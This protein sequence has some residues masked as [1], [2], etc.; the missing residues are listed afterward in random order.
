MADELIAING[1]ILGAAAGLGGLTATLFFLTAQLRT[2]GLSQHGIGDLYTVRLIVPLLAVTSAI[3][4]SSTSGMVLAPSATQLSKLLTTASALQMLPFVI[5]VV[6]LA[7]LTIVYFEPMAVARR[8]SGRLRYSDVRE[9]QLLAMQLRW[10]SAPAT[11]DRFEFTCKIR[12]NRMNFGLRDPLMSI[13]ELI[14]SSR[15]KQFG[16]LVGTLFERLSH[17][18]GLRWNVQAPDPQDWLTEDLSFRRPREAGTRGSIV[19]T[20][21][22]RFSLFM[23][24]VHYARRIA[25]NNTITNVPPDVRRQQ[26]QF[27]LI[28]L[29]LLLARLDKGEGSKAW[30]LTEGELRVASVLCIYAAT[31]LSSQFREVKP[32]GRIEPAWALFTVSQQ[33]ELNGWKEEAALTLK[34]LAWIR[35]NTEHLERSWPNS[36]LDYSPML[37]SD[38]L[39]FNLD[40]LKDALYPTLGDVEDPWEPWNSEIYHLTQDG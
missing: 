39:A 29:A 12:S 16:R 35:A 17:E 32:S 26:A 28:R 8:F 24:I 15:N 31:G 19:N 36:P 2:A 34:S 22:D 40:E 9:W 4:C 38:L 10:V 20:A 7:L 23:L 21:S 25:G 3:I 1:A 18:Y 5:I 13:H 37:S 6:H 11:S 27:L 14:S 33:M 30:R